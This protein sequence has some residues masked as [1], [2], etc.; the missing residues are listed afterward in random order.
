VSATYPLDGAICDGVATANYDPFFPTTPEDELDALAMCR[1]CP[2][3]QACL[4]YAVETG[5]M[6]GIWGGKTQRQLRRLIRAHGGPPRRRVPPSHGNA[7][8]TH[9]AYGHPYDPANT[10][11]TPTGERRCRAC[12]RVRVARARRLAR[13]ASGGER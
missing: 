4:A 3:R 5:Q 2:A 6:F 8:K 11:Y 12:R 10:Y 7:S 13:M 1:I 9:C